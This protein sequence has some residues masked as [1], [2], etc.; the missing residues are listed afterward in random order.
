MIASAELD[1]LV[2]ERVMGWERHRTGIFGQAR[3]HTDRLDQPQPED[4]PEFSTDIAAAWLVMDKMVELL[5]QNEGLRAFDGPIYKP[6]HRYLTEEGY[7]LGTTCW[8]VL[9]ETQDSQEFVCAD[10]APLA[11]CLAALEVANALDLTPPD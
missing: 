1:A 2:A 7:P 10:T 8:Y 5:D 9:V 11:I 6:S 4:C 3:F